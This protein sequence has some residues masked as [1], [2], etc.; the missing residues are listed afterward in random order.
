MPVKRLDLRSAPF[1]RQVRG[2]LLQSERLRDLLCDGLAHNG[3]G[4]GGADGG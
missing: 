4:I 1:G 3:L 2:L